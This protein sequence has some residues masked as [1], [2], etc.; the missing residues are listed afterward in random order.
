M[1]MYDD[2]F[3]RDTWADNGTYPVLDQAVS[4]SPDVLPLGTQAFTPAAIASRYNDQTLA[5]GTIVANNLNNIYVRAKNASTTTP[6]SGQ[7]YLRWAPA[8][9]LVQPTQWKSNFIRN[10]NTLNYASLAQTLPGAVV[11]GDQPFGF[12]PSPGMPSHFCLIA[13][14]TNSHGDP[15]PTIDFTTWQQFVDWVRGNPNVS[16]HNV[17]VVASLPAQGYLAS[18]TFENPAQTQQMF[19]FITQYSGIPAGSL[20]RVWALP[21]PT[22]GF[23]GFD[24]TQIPISGT[25]SNTIGAAFPAGYATTVFTQCQFPGNPPTPPAGATMETTSNGW[26]PGFEGYEHF[27]AFSMTAAEFGLDAAELGGGSGGYFV[28]ITSFTTNFVSA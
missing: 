26:V 7:L 22:Q 25:G 4:A 11:A 24:T 6:R 21:N 13:T 23:Y 9:L 3:V 17:D 12:T 16:W 20:L 18:L 2:L 1:A 19:G 28:P 5:G 27:E 10:D 8:N 15:T 14:I